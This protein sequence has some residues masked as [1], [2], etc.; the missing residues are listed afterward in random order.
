MND[1]PDRSDRALPVRRLQIPLGSPQQQPPPADTKFSASLLWRGLRR[2][3]WQSSLIWLIGTCA[4]VAAAY[5]RIKPT[6][7]ATAAISI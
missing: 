3:W 6:Y 2:Y 7:D 1:M 4:L 5:Y